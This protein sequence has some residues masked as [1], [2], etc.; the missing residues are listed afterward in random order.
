VSADLHRFKGILATIA[1]QSPHLGVRDALIAA[2]KIEL[3]LLSDLPELL[4][5]EEGAELVVPDDFTAV[6]IAAAWCR[7]QPIIVDYVVATKKINAIKEARAL[8]SMS[9]KAAKDAVEYM[10]THLLP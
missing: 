3:Q 5:R 8:S 4:E 2:R 7:A 6:D 1:L 9:L 10:E